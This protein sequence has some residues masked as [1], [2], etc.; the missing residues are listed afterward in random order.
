MWGLH[1]VTRRVRCHQEAICATLHPGG[2]IRA[3]S[4][5]RRV[6]ARPILI[7]DD[8]APIVEL[9]RHYLVREGLAVEDA[10]KGRDGLEKWQALDAAVVMLDLMLPGMSGTDLCREIRKTSQVP[11]LMLTAKDD[12]IDK[13][14]G[15][16]LGA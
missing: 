8:E 15:F 6:M 16:E 14:V 5:E 1:G 4:A 12:L 9:V 11:I 7:V 2:T 3:D 13:V 10:A